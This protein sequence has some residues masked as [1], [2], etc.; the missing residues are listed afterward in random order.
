ME[1]DYKFMQSEVSNVLEQVTLYVVVDDDQTRHIEAVCTSAAEAQQTRQQLLRKAASVEVPGLC[2]VGLSIH[3][4]NA[5]FPGNRY[6]LVYGTP[7]SRPKT[8]LEVPAFRFSPLT[9]T[10]AH[11]E[12]YLYPDD[13]FV[14]R[15]E[16]LAIAA[17]H[18]T[19]QLQRADGGELDWVVVVEIGE[20]LWRRYRSECM[21]RGSVGWEETDLVRPVRVVH[22]TEE[23]A[24]AGEPK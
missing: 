5:T 18:N 10:D 11:S 13:L 24:T 16:A 9:N 8:V 23:E 1:T 2:A 21:V 6:R 19:L 12:G 3:A 7:K 17:E 22:P 4:M 20:P 15:S 14:Q